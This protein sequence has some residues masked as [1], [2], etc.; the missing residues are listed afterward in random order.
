LA[1]RPDLSHSVGFAPHPPEDTP[2]PAKRFPLYTDLRVASIRKLIPI[3]ADGSPDGTREP[4]FSGQTTLMTNA[5][6]V[7]VSCP[8][9]ARTLEE[10]TAKFPEAIKQAVERLVDE[11]REMQRREMSRI[12]VPGTA[13]IPPLGGSGG[14][15]KIDLG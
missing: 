13:N 11:A 9:E 6:P 10:A 12:V 14:G 3:K 8:I 2:W 15:G 5:G 7:P 4:L 1:A